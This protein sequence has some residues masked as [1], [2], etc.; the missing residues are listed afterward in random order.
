MSKIAVI[1]LWQANGQGQTPRCNSVE[2]L[3]LQDIT[4]EKYTGPGEWLIWGST[5]AVLGTACVRDLET[6]PMVVDYG[7]PFLVSQTK[8]GR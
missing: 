5:N 1:D 2:S 7:D 4:Q 6:L 8:I 3:H